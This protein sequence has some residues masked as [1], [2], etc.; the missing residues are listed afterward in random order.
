A[1]SPP[2]LPVEVSPEVPRSAPDPARAAAAPAR[3][4][5]RGGADFGLDA[6][7]YRRLTRACPAL[8]ANPFLGLMVGVALLPAP[9]GFHIGQK[10]GAVFDPAQNWIASNISTALRKRLTQHRL[11]IEIAQVRPIEEGE[12]LRQARLLFGRRGDGRRPLDA[13]LWTLAYETY[14]AEPPELD[15]GLR[16]RLRGFPNF[17]RLP[18]VPD[19]FL[20]MAAHC[21][22]G[23]QS[24]ASLQRH[25]AGQDAR[26]MA[27]FVV[28]A[29]L[30]GLAAVLPAERR[31]D[32]PAAAAAPADAAAPRGR[33]RQLLAS[34]F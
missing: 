9:H 11:M 27:L 23:P 28:C 33:V 14:A 25:F 26:Q 10:A 2:E 7:S 30:S 6:A 31:R 3:R 21:L 4:R 12:A 29:V 17:T 20:R 34:L 24:L 22:R 13:Y 15:P 18:P 19:L 8:V 32:A 16:I 5:A 1:H